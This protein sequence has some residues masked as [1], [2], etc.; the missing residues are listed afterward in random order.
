MNRAVP[1]RFLRCDRRAVS[2][3]D[4]VRRTLDVAPDRAP[5]FENV[6][7][8]GTEHWVS[9]TLSTLTGHEAVLHASSAA[10]QPSGD[11]P[12]GPSRPTDRAG[13]PPRL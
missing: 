6:L 7:K 2:E 9:M 10:H 5:D 12:S 11:R 13:E 3:I 4:R 8:S 1:R